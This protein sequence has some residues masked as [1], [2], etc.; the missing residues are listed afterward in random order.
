MSPNICTLL[1]QVLMSCA[2]YTILSTLSYFIIMDGK[3]LIILRYCINSAQ[4]WFGRSSP[5]QKHVVFEICTLFLSCTHIMLYWSNSV[6]CLV[7][8]MNKIQVFQ[9]F[10]SLLF[11]AFIIFCL[12]LG[13]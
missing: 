3:V 6:L 5:S 2:N 8:I 7:C 10:L 11:L 13:Y 9:M 12:F 1:V 4:F